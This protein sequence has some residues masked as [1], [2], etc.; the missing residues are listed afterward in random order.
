MA[1]I[2]KSTQYSRYYGEFS[3]IDLS[4]S[5]GNLE[6]TRCC[7]MRNMYRDYYGND[8]SAIETVPGF[9]R[10][11]SFSVAGERRRINSLLRFSPRWAEGEH[12]A[13]HAGKRL[14]FYPID[15]KDSE[16]ELTLL[17]ERLCS[18]DGAQEYASLADSKSRMFEHNGE[19]F[20]LDGKDY[21]RATDEGV[22]SIR[23]LA[24]VPTTYSDGEAYE[25]RNLLTDSFYCK[26]NLSQSIRIL[27][28]YEYAS[29]GL[30]Y[31][32]TGEGVCEVVGVTDRDATELF[33]PSQTEI[34]GQI[35]YV[36]SIAPIAFREMT[37]LERVTVRN[38]IK[39]IGNNAFLLCTSLS[40]VYLPDSVE[41]LGN[42]LFLRCDNLKT[43]TLGPKITVIPKNTFYGTS[44]H[45]LYYSGSSTQWASVTVETQNT[46]LENAT[47]VFD[48]RNYRGDFCFYINE[49]CETL[50][51]VTLDGAPLTQ[52]NFEPVYY[53]LKTETLDGAELVSSI[54]IHASDYTSLYDKVLQ[55]KGKTA[56]A[57]AKK[58][59]QGV[60]FNTGADIDGYS[61]VAECTVCARFDGRVF[62]SGNPRFPS[63][64]FYSARGP[65][66]ENDP[67][68]VGALNYFYV[69]REDSAVRAL[70]ASGDCLAVFK[71]DNEKGGV[72]L[73]SGAD[74]QSDLLPRVYTLSDSV[75]GVGSRG[76]GCVFY[77][78]TVF[79]S[80]RGLDA[81]GKKQLN[82]EIS[83]EHRSSNIDAALL[84]GELS[85]VRLCF[86][87]GYLALLRDG[88]IFLADSRQTFRHRT[89]DTQYEWYRL[90]D[91]GTYENQRTRFFTV[92]LTEPYE[93]LYVKHGESYLP[94]EGRADSGEEAEN[95]FS[96][97]AYEIRD[98]EFKRT[99]VL[100]YC[101]IKHDSEGIFHCYMCDSE[102]EMT[103]GEY[104]P[105]CEICSADEL[106]FF[107]TAGGDLCCFNTDKRDAAGSIDRRYYTFD[108]RR[109]FS[110]FS[111]KSDNCDV[112]N[113]T[114][115]TVKHSLC[116]HLRSFG[117]G[118]VKIMV[119]TDQDKWRSI[120]EVQSGVFSFDD[121]EFDRFTFNTSPRVTLVIPEKE[122]RWSEKQYHIY[123]DEYKRP[124][125][126][127]DIS[128]RFKVAGRIKEK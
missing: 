125:G 19:L 22:S 78:D 69:G 80:E 7:D 57:S 96:A 50:Y 82:G 52:L 30:I 120:S 46:D 128:Y 64:V 99:D 58:G 98:G 118:Q 76:E 126:I 112:T 56:N 102:G 88:D 27:N 62:Y 18:S 39:R 107:G 34:N 113:M 1:S 114:K 73:Y 97:Y 47:V 42:G 21:L 85:R 77:G 90:S 122:K 110:G 75:L 13:V 12:I 101:N 31:S 84:Q 3:G 60:P 29:D 14:F 36:E 91:V 61:A 115:S 38:G 127:F 33:I 105:A 45:T 86:W 25:Q 70:V 123:S 49:P 65:S 5:A 24:Y 100:V 15:A 6:K 4:S 106:L 68:Y 111:T 40:S 67:T 104:F 63:V 94:L 119:R 103:G 87:Q 81:V 43:V 41:E 9:R 95:A 37:S 48:N 23:E 44:L 2:A 11:H 16:T 108:G 35:Y 28:L 66:G 53:S 89:G 71:S 8:G 93:N 83:I 20:I 74:T 51:S 116:M 10:L 117:S 124:F 109:Y 92:A 54:I 32:I 72:Y 79:I 121:T 26:F 17:P 59:A 55:I